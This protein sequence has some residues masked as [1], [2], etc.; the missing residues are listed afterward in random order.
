MQRSLLQKYVVVFSNTWQEMVTYRVNTLIE[1]GMGF[2]TF[3]SMYFVWTEMFRDKVSIL[4]YSM[5]DMIAYYALIGYILSSIV[6]Y[7]PIADEIRTGQLSKYLTRPISY[8][9]HHYVKNLAER[10]Y[11]LMIGLPAVFCLFYYFRDV[12]Q[13]DFDISRFVLSIIALFGAISIMF[14][15]SSLLAIIEFWM[16]YSDSITMI[17]ELITFFLAGSFIPLEF[18]PS[19]LQQLG[20]VLPFKYVGAFLVEIFLG[21]ISLQSAML[22]IVIQGVWVVFLLLLIRFVWKRGLRRYEANGN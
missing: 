3:F 18:L 10:I 6:S 11:F 1:L 14:L 19:W 17:T 12:I 5:G 9:G 22:G 21:R 15:L 16:L 7:V 4:G 8:F 2:L 13:V 20:A